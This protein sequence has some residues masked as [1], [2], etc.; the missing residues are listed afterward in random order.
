M[1]T[2]IAIRLPGSP[3]ARRG[4]LL[5]LLGLLFACT[6]GASPLSP[7][8]LRC[9]SDR[10]LCLALEGTPRV[11][12]PFPLTLYLVYSNLPQ[13]PPVTLTLIAP[14]SLEL[15]ALET[16]RPYQTQSNLP[17]PLVD[18]AELSFEGHGTFTATGTLIT[19]DLG[20]APTGKIRH[21]LFGNQETAGETMR[22][23]ARVK[24]AGEWQLR[25][26]LRLP[27][28]EHFLDG[29]TE[30]HTYTSWLDLLGWSTPSQAYWTDYETAIHDY[31][32]MNSEQCRDVHPA[33]RG[34]TLRFP[35]DP[36]RYLIGAPAEAPGRPL[37]ERPTTFCSSYERPGPCI[38]HGI[39]EFHPFEV[40]PPESPTPLAPT[41]TSTALTFTLAISFT[42]P[43][44]QLLPARGVRVEIWDDANPSEQCP[45]RPPAT[46]TPTPGPSPTPSQTP[47]LLPTFIPTPRPAP[48]PPRPL[49]NPVPS[50]STPPGP[51]CFPAQRL[52]TGY[53][54]PQGQLTLTFSLGRD[55]TPELYIAIYPKDDRR[56]TVISFIEEVK[57][58]KHYIG[59]VWPIVYQINIQ[60]PSSYTVFFIYDTLTRLGWEGLQREVGW[61][62]PERLNVYWPGPCVFGQIGGSC[63][64]YNGIRLTEPDG[65]S[66]DAILHEFGHFVLSR[67]HGDNPIILACA[68]TFEHAFPQHTSL[69]CAWSEGWA[70][71]L[72]AALLGQPRYQGWDLEDPLAHPDFPR[73]DPVDPHATNADNEWAT[74]AALWDLFDHLPEPWDPHAD[75]W[76]GPARNG[77]WTLST[78][79]GF[80]LDL[81][82]EEF[83]LK[84][85]E[86][87]P[88]RLGEAACPM[89][90][91]QILLAADPSV[92]PIP[93][94]LCPP[95]WSA[96][97]FQDQDDGRWTLNGPI[98]WP[99]FTALVTQT[100]WPA[101]AFN[102]HS[103]PNQPV[104]GLRGTFWSARFSG[105]LLVP[106]PASLRF[107]FD[108]LDDG[109][110]LLLN[111]TRVFESWIVH[112][113]RDETVEPFL[114]AGLIPITVEYA[115]GPAYEASL[116]L[117]WEGPGWAKELL[118][119]IRL[120]GADIAP[121]PTPAGWD[122]ISPLGPDRR[123]PPPR[124]TGTPSP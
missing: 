84:W 89:Y 77:I 2:S 82:I 3:A 9:T 73:I 100:T 32:R 78:Q 124:P 119:P 123:T 22:L 106:Q 85:V 63:Y 104:P 111:D 79:R 45:P 71:F 66:P 4:L 114:P 67:F 33:S 81:G 37:R 5:L 122:R 88:D 10:R 23:V 110:R 64:F 62:P 99:T 24:E 98:T 42:A 72:A 105:W 27:V 50:R 47:P 115:Q 19:V 38:E 96:A 116:F 53:T 68:P 91:L 41:P 12:Q 51:Q 13:E 15:I 113:P 17:V 49:L 75:G 61:S 83:W 14:S 118:G 97:F 103:A 40:L 43:T 20:H 6:P 102:T 92:S 1:A 21:P 112:G 101:I 34:C 18:P 107:F 74:A 44:G 26:I 93:Y 57:L 95:G 39:Y 30:L 108:R 109:G 48:T 87:R 86:R 56:V 52:A 28:E 55:P 7:S 58:Y 121:T 80:N 36:Y 8:P 11:G 60:I 35:Y 54:D 65:R 29:R 25:S 120:L 94:G 31:A 59:K 70:S 76:D 117:N 16:Q 46:L 90:R 69:H